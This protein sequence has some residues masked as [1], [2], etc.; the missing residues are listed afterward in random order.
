KDIPIDFGN[1][2]GDI[3]P[4]DIESVTVLKG[5]A[6]TALYG[7]RAGNGALIITTKKGSK[8]TGGVGI[9]IN[10][11]SSINDILRWPDM[12]YEYGQGNNNRNAAG[13][14]Y[15]S[16][17]LSEDG[18]NTGSTSSAFGPKFDGQ[19]YYQYDP[20]IEGQSTERLPWRP[21]KDNV[22]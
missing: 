11:N 15:Y 6:A 14:L 3:N 22:K 12:Q 13:E 7:S 8:R 1:G 21:Y 5:A 16:Y 20:T 2:L 4:D 10:S 9:T 19:D 17:Q 18:P